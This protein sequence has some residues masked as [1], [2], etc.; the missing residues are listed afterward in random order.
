MLITE[1]VFDSDGVELTYHDPNF[2]LV[3]SDEDPKV[4]EYGVYEVH[5]F[6]ASFMEII[7][8]DGVRVRLIDYDAYTNVYADLE[9]L[10]FEE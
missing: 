1:F 6:D 3:V 2:P 8:R 5:T 9:D 10:T 7:N 4:L